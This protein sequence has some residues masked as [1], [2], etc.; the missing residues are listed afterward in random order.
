MPHHHRALIIGTLALCSLQALA[1]D[2]PRLDQALPA[3][4][5]IAAI[6][7]VFDFDGDG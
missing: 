6:H 7:P 2:Y 4:I 5:N 1:A 3:N